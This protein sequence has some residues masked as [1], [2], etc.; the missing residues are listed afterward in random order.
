M[1][2]L[3][4]AICVAVTVCV[5]LIFEVTAERTVSWEVLEA[6]LRDAE[7]VRICFLFLSCIKT[8]LVRKKL[9]LFV[10]RIQEALENELYRTA[11]ERDKRGP[12]NFRFRGAKRDAGDE[13]RSGFI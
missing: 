3:R 5:C 4:A 1:V 9:I 2:L 7:R 12:L 10:L 13:V 6:A 8:H 11:D